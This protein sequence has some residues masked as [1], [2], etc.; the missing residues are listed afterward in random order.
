MAFWVRTVMS[1]GSVLV[2]LLPMGACGGAGGTTAEPV[3]VR[4]S[5]STVDAWR[6]RWRP[7]A[8]AFWDRVDAWQAATNT[9]RTDPVATRGAAP[10]IVAAASEWKA[11]LVDGDL[12]GDV[13]AEATKLV[14]AIDATA[15]TWRTIPTCG[16]DAACI[17]A[18]AGRA[19]TDLY[20]IRSAQ[21]AL[22]P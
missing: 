3:A 6:D 10:A 21:F 17:A 8:E 11:A 5:S 1:L 9:G 12:P 15:A 2:A 19:G 22:R 20:D 7:A 13:T 14:G 18:N 4:A 16:D